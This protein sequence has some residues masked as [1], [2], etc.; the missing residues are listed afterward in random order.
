MAIHVLKTWG[1]PGEAATT[2]CRMTGRQHPADPRLFK[3]IDGE[4]RAVMPNDTQFGATC[5]DCRRTMH[6]KK[7]D[8]MNMR[9]L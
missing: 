8:K 1:K 9:L 6:A 3:G 7:T 2:V 4:F 5:A